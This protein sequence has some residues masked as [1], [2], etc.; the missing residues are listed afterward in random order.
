[1]IAQHFGTGGVHVEAPNGFKD[2][3]TPEA[4][5]FRPQCWVVLAFNKVV[6][7]DVFRHVFNFLENVKEHAPPLAGAHSETGGEG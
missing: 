3:L 2:A 4:F 1:M 7:C 6:A 5:K